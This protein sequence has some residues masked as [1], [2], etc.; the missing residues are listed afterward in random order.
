MTGV[1]VNSFRNGGK[2]DAELLGGKGANLAEMTKA[3][4][5]VPPGFT[6][7]TEMCRQYYSNGCRLPEGL[8]DEVLR[9]MVELERVQQRR[10]G[11]A[12]CPL[13]VSVR[14]GAVTS[15]PG[16]MD[17]ILNL[18]LTD[19]TVEGLAKL[20][21]NRRFAYDCYR[22]FIQMYGSVVYNIE[23]VHFERIL[24]QEKL[25]AGCTEDQQLTEESLNSLV[26]KF[27]QLI[28]VRSERLFPQ[29]VKQQLQ[30]AVEAVFLSWSSPRAKVYRKV[31]HIPHDQ[32]TA[33][34]IQSMVFGN[35]GETSGTG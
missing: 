5:P 16:M 1:R 29:D 28:E 8:M 12:E 22:R 15:M 27:K 35:M 17:T 31:H 32:G 7:T 30:E 26:Q 6:I 13:L 24:Q 14:S 3:G 19:Q 23:A 11:S 33:V 34:N 2:E 20:T 21:H 9:A 10:F 25:L 18:G 4:L